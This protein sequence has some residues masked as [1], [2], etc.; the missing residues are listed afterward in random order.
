MQQST[1]RLV[2]VDA[3]RGIVMFLLLP[4]LTGGFSFHKM[5][6]QNPDDPV[7]ANLAAWFTHVQWSGASVW[8]LVMPSFVFLVGVA[9][10]LSVAA[11]RH[12]GDSE[13]QIFGHVVL[14]AATLFLLALILQIPLRTYLDELWPFMLLAAGL[15]VPERL[16]AMFGIAS[17]PLRHRIELL[18][19][20]AILIASASRV[21]ANI[22]AL[23]NYEFGHVFSQLALASICAFL[24]VGKSR[25]VQLGSMFA[26]LVCYWALFVIYPLPAPGFDPSKVGVRP[27]DEVFNGLFAHW[28]KNTNAAAAFDVWFLNLLPRAEPFLFQG[29]GLQTL[30]FVP[31]IATMISGVMAGDLLLSGQ[32]RTQIRD[33]LL[34]AGAAA[35]VAGLFAGQWLCPIV[36]SIWTPSWVLFSSGVT[37][38]VLAALYQLCDVCEWRAWALPFAV[39]G[40]NSVLLY[41]LAYY[42]WW[43][44]SI[45]K[46]LTGVDPFTGV[47]A[48]VLESIV[49]VAMLWT[50][51]YVLYRARIFVKV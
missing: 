9:M 19:W 42:K 17:A 37:I 3:Y 36:K 18:W 48:P 31:T 51:A 46:K 49:L 8:D 32:A 23:G 28:N 13:R 21:L 34:L 6:R 5:A 47:H 33:T 11:R 27:T 10:P 41:T 43:F 35:L 2:A 15:P 30:N 12:R 24:L 45:P 1:D 26:I 14:R 25:R 22:G 7:W 40:A 50:I 39:L 4:D 29:N 16:T 44:I 20:S 38:L